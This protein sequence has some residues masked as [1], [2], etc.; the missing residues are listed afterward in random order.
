M[1]AIWAVIKQKFLGYWFIISAIALTVLWLITDSRGRKIGELQAAAQTQ[2]LRQQL[3]TNQ[4]NAQASQESYETSLKEY[5][6]L[7]A[8]HGDLLTKLGVPSRAPVGP[9]DGSPKAS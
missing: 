6:D 4:S 7:L 1:E 3:A 2:L 8:R 9:N 5:N